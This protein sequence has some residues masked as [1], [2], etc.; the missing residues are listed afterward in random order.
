[1]RSIHLNEHMKIGHIVAVYPGGMVRDSDHGLHE[2]ESLIETLD[3]DAGSIMK[4]HE[5]AW[6]E[7]IEAAGWEVFTDGYSGQDSYRGP[8]MH[9][10]EYIGG[11][12]ERDILERPGLYVAVSVECLPT[13]SQPE[14]QVA[15][16]VVLRRDF[17]GI[18]KH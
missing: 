12:L 15:G 4:E 7:R 14:P 6:R 17:P 3:D 18:M 2:P 16:W 11:Q 5:D 13:E 1:M 8:I 10:S 9:P